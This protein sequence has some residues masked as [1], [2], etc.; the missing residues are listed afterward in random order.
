M[1]GYAFPVAASAAEGLGDGLQGP[2][3]P[4]GE[5]DATQDAELI[6][7]VAGP[8]LGSGTG[9]SRATQKSRKKEW[10][11]ACSFPAEPRQVFRNASSAGDMELPYPVVIGLA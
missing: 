8:G 5:E 4:R 7:E 11:L 1:G 3:P 6:L 10:K 2:Q 9:R